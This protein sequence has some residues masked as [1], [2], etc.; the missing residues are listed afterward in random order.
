[1]SNSD[2]DAAGIEQRLQQMAAAIQTMEEQFAMISENES[3][4]IMARNSVTSAM[5]SLKGIKENDDPT[6]SSSP[7]T[8]IQIGGGVII[9]AKTSASDKM[10]LDIGSGVLVEKDHSEVLNYLENRTR[11]IDITIKNT[12][13]EKSNLR[14]HLEQYKAQMNRAMQ[15]MYG[16]Q[17][18]IGNV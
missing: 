3:S 9:P 17:G 8:L 1:M 18:Q 15:A 10:L 2:V 14:H 6:D 12:S 7:K 13:A 11:E 16:N 5:E 4:A